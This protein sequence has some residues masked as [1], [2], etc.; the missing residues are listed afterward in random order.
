M[1]RKAI[2]LMGKERTEEGVIEIYHLLISHEKNKN[3]LALYRGIEERTKFMQDM[4]EGFARTLCSY[5]CPLNI[6]LVNGARIKEGCLVSS[7]RLE[8][9]VVQQFSDILSSK[10][11]RHWSTADSVEPTSN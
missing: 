7:Y 9:Q 1:K 3:M 10:M 4:A 11:D 5:G 6:K 2:I 8:E